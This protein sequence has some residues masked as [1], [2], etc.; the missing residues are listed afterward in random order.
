MSRKKTLLLALLSITVLAILVAGVM[1][2]QLKQGRSTPPPVGNPVLNGDIAPAP[3]LPRGFVVWSSNRY[4]NHDI[5]RMQLPQRKISRLTQHPHTE[6]FP[7][8]A[9]NGQAI[10]FARSQVPWVSQR[11]QV[12]WDVILLDLNNGQERLL[13]KNGNT[14]TW[15]AD[16]SHVYFQR[17]NTQFVEIN[18]KTGQERTLY[19]SGTGDIR[20]GAVLQ[21]PHY[22][23]RSGRVA[24]TLRGAQH[25]IGI[26]D[27]NGKFTRIADGCQLTWSKQGDF[28]YYIDYGGRMKNALYR[29]D[30]EKGESRLWMD[31]PGEFSH[32][33][34]PK[35][36][37]DERYLVYGASSGGH[38]HDSADYEIFLWKLGTPLT[39]VT[40][41]SFHT[42]NDNWPDVY[43]DPENN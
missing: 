31:I 40:R 16:G 35:L 8:I 3:G 38:E 12:P 22:D 21:T 25:K 6:Y 11:N 19:T 13:A 42:G 18:V 33:Y 2:W 30:P 34:F 39:E 24:V 28:L 20:D 9:P 36:S 17:N 1:R 26:M 4:G 32:E 10:V 27:L 43:I 7:R 41:L 23:A 29:Y 5:L 15:S 37:N 14:P